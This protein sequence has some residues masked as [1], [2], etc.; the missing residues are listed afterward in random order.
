MVYIREL[1]LPCELFKFVLFV[2]HCGPMAICISGA[3]K[4]DHSLANFSH[5]FN[6]LKK[7]GNDKSVHWEG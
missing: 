5:H 4:K 2:E 1:K 3:E 7:Q 6:A